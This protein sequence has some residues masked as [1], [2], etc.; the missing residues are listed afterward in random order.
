TINPLPDNLSLCCAIWGLALFFQWHSN[1][2]QSNL[3][4]SGIFLSIATLSKL[5]FILFYVVPFT[6]FI[7]QIKQNG[8]K[9]TYIYQATSAFIFVLLPT[10][11]YLS[12]ISEWEGNPV[13][14]GILANSESILTIL[15]Y[16]QHNLIIVLPEMLL[17][18]ASVPFFLLGIYFVF[19]NKSYK[20][21]KSVLLTSLLVMALFYYLFEA[22]AIKKVHDYY[23]F[24]FMPL[25]FILVSYGAYNLIKQ[26]KNV[27]KYITII[28][29]LV[30]PITCFLRLNNVRWDP[31]RPGF[32][33]DLLM[34]KNEL[35]AA[36]PKDALVVA[37]NDISHYIFLYYIDKKGWAFD[38]DKIT[39]SALS[40]MIQKGAK[41][42]YSST[43]LLK[44]NENFG[45]F[46]DELILERGSIRVYKLKPKICKK[47]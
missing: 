8:L 47:K 7:Y 11:W 3:V 10:A 38:N 43:N 30:M 36:I 45:H 24:P 18:Y 22:N 6:Y 44:I 34:H 27:Y 32:N 14:K 1:Q 13:V 16:I 25:L 12:V 28:I 33:K 29:L 5:P 31:E 15:D 46:L 2:K 21:K 35:R 26:K 9:S 17:N 23:F 20:N 4:L 37:G 19:K 40:N 39:P 42:I 41:Y